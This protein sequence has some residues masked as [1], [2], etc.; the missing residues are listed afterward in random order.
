M[1]ILEIELAPEMEQRLREKAKRHGLES[2]PLAQTVMLLALL[3]EDTLKLPKHSIIELEGLGTE[4]WKDENGSLVDAQ[5]YVDELRQE[6][7]HRP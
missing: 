6:W 1:S 4:I 7:D 2:R 5:D 3:A